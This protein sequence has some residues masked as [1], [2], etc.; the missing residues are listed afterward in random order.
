MWKRPFLKG[1]CEGLWQKTESRAFKRGVV[2]EEDKTGIEKGDVL[3]AFFTRLL[4][5][6]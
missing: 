6:D 4:V 2:G 1:A 3:S 5:Q